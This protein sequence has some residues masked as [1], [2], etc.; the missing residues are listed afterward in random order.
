MNIEL[1]KK[2]CSIKGASSEEQNIAEFILNEIKDYIDEHSIDALG[3]LIA[4]KKGSGKKMMLAGHMDQIGMMVTHIDKEGFIWFT[5]IGGLSPT[6]IHSARVVFSNGTTG[7]LGCERLED[8][9]K[10]AIDK[11]YIDIGAV[12]KEEAEKHVSIGDICV[13]SNEP[14]VDEHKIIT[15]YLDDRIG[16]Y[17]MIEALKKLKNPAF[18]LYFVFTVQEEVGLRGAKTAAYSVDPDYGLSFDVTISADTPKCRKLPQK[19]DGGACIKIKDSSLICHPLIVKHMEKCA[20]EADIKY[21]FEI[22]ESGGTDSGAIHVNKGG[23]PSG[24]LSIPTRHIH[25]MNEM[26]RLSD[27]SDCVDLTVKILETDIHG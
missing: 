15:P 22:L 16:C 14:V 2:I 8:P 17:V 6:V 21:Q 12:S 19:F 23:V 13:F 26:A 10:I 24:V 9:A 18:D 7:I 11:M 25:S 4:R 1:L 5:N 3:N 27:I 20:K